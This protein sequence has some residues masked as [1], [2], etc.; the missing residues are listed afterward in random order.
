ML[1]FDL[2]TLFP[3]LFRSFLSESLIGKALEK[4]LFQVELNNFREFGLGT[5]HQVDDE[6][7][8]GG[9]GMLLRVEPI[10]EALKTR[11][12]HHRQN[13]RSVKK[14]LLTPQGKPF[15]QKKAMQWSESEEVLVLVC[16]RYEGFDERIRGLIDEEVSGGDFV[17]FGG[18]VVAMLIIE[19]V[20]R[21]VPGVLGNPGSPGTESFADNLLEYPQYTRPRTY[22]GMEVPEALLSGNHS[23]I[24]AWRETQALER[25]RKRRPD[26]LTQSIE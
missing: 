4:Q 2:L 1:H 20:S 15:N 19:T 8:G 22:Q 3:E 10:A 13:D 6:P 7:F 11:E 18:E 21:L 16:G 5:H 14:V 25:T 26:L 12:Q 23:R 17:C 24:Q 9:P